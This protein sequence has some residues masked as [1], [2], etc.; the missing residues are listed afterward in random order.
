V[1]R[2]CSFVIRRCSL[3]VRGGRDGGC[4]GG[5]GGGRGDDHGG[6]SLDDYCVTVRDSSLF[7]RDSWW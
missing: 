1:I 7:V 6:S 2:R 3:V 4:G 5:R